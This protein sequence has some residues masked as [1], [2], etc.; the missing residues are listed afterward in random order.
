MDLKKVD[1]SAL[2]SSGFMPQV[3]KDRFSMRLRVA[4]GHITAEQLKKV[5]EIAAE[6]GQGYVHMTSRQSIEIPFI[7]LEDIETVKG[8]LAKAGLE[9]A[10]G[11][12]R[13]R[14]IT[15][16]QGGTVCPRGLIDTATLVGEINERYYGRAVP[17][18]FKIGITGC[19]NN[20]LKA[21][22]NDLGI[23]G[24]MKPEWTAQSCTYCGACGAICPEKAITVDKKEKVLV[25]SEKQC[26]QCGKCVKACPAKAW[27][28]KSGY[29]LYF[30]GTFGNRIRIG[31]QLI[32]AVF[33][34]EELHEI[35]EITLDFFT[36]HGK[37]KER[38]A[39]MLERIGRDALER[40]L[41][42]RG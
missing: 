19:R 40:A 7:R 41:Q 42:E 4:G 30:G 8:K 21:E 22:E 10:A 20:C 36:K 34:V 24:A 38:F 5:Y 11:G 26:I 1:Y 35:I 32:P 17:H 6:F 33:T 16:C 3:Q 31:S 2:K 12:N 28:G 13:V 14:T 29:I 39:Y 18:K 9:P 37:A 27:E 15:A 25:Y 23:K